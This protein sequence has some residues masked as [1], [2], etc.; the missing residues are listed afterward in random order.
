[1]RRWIVAFVALLVGVAT[2]NAQ[3]MSDSYYRENP[4][5]IDAELWALE[6]EPF[7]VAY[8]HTIV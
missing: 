8:E 1:M 7:L 3:P 2:M 6:G 4:S 5:W